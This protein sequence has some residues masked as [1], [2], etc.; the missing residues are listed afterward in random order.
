MR[1]RVGLDRTHPRGVGRAAA[2]GHG[3]PQE[4]ARPRGR[5]SLLGMLHPRRTQQAVDLRGADRPQ[6][7]LKRFRPRRGAPPVMFEP[8][9]QRRPEQLA[10][11]LIA[12]Q[13]HGLEHR[14]DDDRI[15]RA[16]GGPGRLGGAVGRGRCRS[17]RAA[18][19]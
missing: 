16:L 10:A 13:P 18:L 12:G 7:F 8:F 17:R 2:R 3:L 1:P 11:Q 4:R 5:E 14:R 19:R 6:F 9:G 15:V